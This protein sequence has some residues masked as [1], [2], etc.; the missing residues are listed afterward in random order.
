M[1]LL[2][3][4]ARERAEAGVKLQELVLGESRSSLEKGESHIVQ[5]EALLV[6]L[7]PFVEMWLYEDT[8]YG[9]GKLCNTCVPGLFNMCNN[10]TPHA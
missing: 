1:N 3:D 7:E 4:M 8:V 2:R 6:Q 10:T 9:A 5:Y